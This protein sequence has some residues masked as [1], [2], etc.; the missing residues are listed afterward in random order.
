[1]DDKIY[2]SM[3]MTESVTQQNGRFD[4]VRFTNAISKTSR[5]R[6]RFNLRALT[7]LP[8]LVIGLL[9]LSACKQAGY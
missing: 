1:M 4:Q 8:V 7:L 3:R 5:R 2:A 6:Q 9:L